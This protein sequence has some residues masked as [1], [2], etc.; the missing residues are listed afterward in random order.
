MST[1]DLPV[2]V[3]GAGPVGLAAAAHLVTRGVPVRLYERGETVAS[4]VRSWGHVRLFSPWRY[5]TDDAARALL[6]AHGWQE[7]PGDVLPTGGDL[8]SAYLQPLAATPELK[9][10]IETGARVRSAARQGIDKVVSRNRAG[11]PFALTIET[12]AG[13]TRIDLARGVIDAS[14]TW[15]TPTRSGLREARLRASVPSR[16]ASHTEF[17]MSSAG[18]GRA[19]RASASSSSAEGIRRR[20]RCSISQGSWTPI[21][22]HG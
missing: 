3:I 17:P 18:S 6:R 10:V 11:H 4:H 2:A 14:G 13:A 22:R 12:G 15:S 7:P 20:M 1:H 8:Y 9:A 19:M 21:R 5:N 16:T